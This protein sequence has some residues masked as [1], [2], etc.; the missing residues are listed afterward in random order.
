[1]EIWIIGGILVALMIYVST[2]IKNAARVAYEREVFETDTFTITK[3]N[4][5]IIPVK[6]GSEFVFEAYSRNLGE[7]EAERF[8]QCR[9]TISERDGV[10]NDSSTKEDENIDGNVTIRTFSKTLSNPTLNR[11]LSLKISVLPEYEEK[12]ANGIKLMLES[13]TLK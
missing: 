1:M 7:D 2:K 12:Y 13:F 10:E 3:P 5:F 9:A 8:H 4:E 6:E 11:S